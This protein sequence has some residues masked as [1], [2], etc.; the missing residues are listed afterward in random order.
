MSLRIDQDSQYAG[1]DR[2]QW[3]VWIEADEPSD[4]DEVK[5]VVWILHPS[6]RRSRIVRKT[7]STKFKLEASGWGSFLVRA[8]LRLNNDESLELSANLNLHYPD[9]ADTS[10]VRSMR[11][12]DKGDVPKVFLSYSAADRRMATDVKN[13]LLSIGTQVF[14]LSDIEPGESWASKLG[15]MIR[16][17]DA[18]IGVIGPD[19]ASPAVVRE[20][21][22]AQESGK[23][24]LA[25]VN[26][27]NTNSGLLSN[28]EPLRMYY[29]HGKAQ[30]IGGL[31]HDWLK[32]S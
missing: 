19:E 32:R 15:E 26:E 20:I 14:D 28:L 13:Q 7:R 8:E 9:E 16:Q 10:R 24:V 27:R 22:Q 25:V 3:S 31:V 18:V 29:E 2:W 12:V 23:P 21:Q 4:L 30:P 6:F 17:S 1:R 11:S 5:E